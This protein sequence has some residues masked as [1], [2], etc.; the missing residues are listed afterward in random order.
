[1]VAAMKGWRSRLTEGTMEALEDVV[2][3]ERKQ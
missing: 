3:R 2:M 1:M